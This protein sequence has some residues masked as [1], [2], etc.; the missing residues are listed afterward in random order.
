MEHPGIIFKEL[1]IKKGLSTKEVAGDSVTPQFLNKFERGLS[2][3]RFSTLLQLLTRIN[4]TVAEFSFRL[5]DTLDHWLIKV[6]HEIDQA[7]LNNNSFAFEQ[8][9][10]ENDQL[11]A[12]TG[13]KRY[14]LA[15]LIAR[16]Y[17]NEAMAD[18]YEIDLP[19]AQ[20]YLR[21]TES[22]GRFEL[23]LITY[24]SGL[25]NTE[26]SLIYAR[27]I[28]RKLD[29]D[30]ATNRWRYDAYLHLFFHTMM[31]GDAAAAEALWQDYLSLFK[32][33]RNLEY[34][35]YDL[36]GRFVQGLLRITQGDAAGEVQCQRII[37]TFSEDAGYQ[38]YANRLHI[39][40]RRVLAKYN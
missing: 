30:Y 35:H 7:Y 32:P 19:Y 33:E 36:Y 16:Y 14:R 39:L 10:D 34:L 12:S 5:E 1:R 13:E 37:K 25:F 4:V 17:Y 28:L 40:L 3:I 18:I 20:A 9:I 22:W 38:N 21:E 27:Q 8:F 2:D 24:L 11:Y 6:E 23:F 29:E 15:G 26:E 31:R